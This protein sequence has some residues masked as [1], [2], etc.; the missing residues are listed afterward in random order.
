M[1][2][3]V[4]TQVASQGVVDSR[5]MVMVSYKL[6]DGGIMSSQA[7]RIRDDKRANDFRTLDEKESDRA[8]P[9]AFLSSVDVQQDQGERGT[10]GHG[11]G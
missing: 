10:P 4:G 3:Y 6:L 1:K 9:E 8:E 7:D 11:D 5:L 2:H